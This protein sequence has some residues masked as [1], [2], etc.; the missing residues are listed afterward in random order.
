MLDFD[1][2]ANLEYVDYTSNCITKIENVSFNKYLKVLN[3]SGNKF[4]KIEGINLN[5]SLRVI[6]LNQ[7]LIKN[8]ENFDDMMLEEIYLS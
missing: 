6:N 8:I 1:P 4:Q 7:N 5:K 3:L 2:P